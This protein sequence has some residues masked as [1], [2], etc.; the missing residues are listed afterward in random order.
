[1]TAQQQAVIGIDVGTTAVKAAAFGLG[2]ERFGV[3]TRRVSMANAPL[4]RAE[5]NPIALR[6]AVIDALSA[7][8]R[9]VGGTPVRAVSLS[10]AMHGLIGL[11]AKGHPCTPLVTWADG[12]AEAIV[13]DWRTSGRATAL[14]S[15][16]GVPMHPMTPLA[17]LAWFAAEDPSTFAEVHRWADGK[18]LV[19]GWLTGEQSTELSSASGWGLVDLSTQTWDPAALELAGVDVAHMPLIASPTE[20]RPLSP[21][22][23]KRVG[24]RADT[25]VVLGAGDGPLG[26]VGVGAL[27]PG[28]VGLSLGTSGAL[29]MVFDQVP[30]D[31]DDSLFC[32]S[33]TEQ[34]W[35]VGGAVSNGGD[36][37]SWVASALAPD[38]SELAV[39]VPARRVTDGPRRAEE[40]ALDLASSA[41]PGSDG[42]VMIPYLLPERSP[43]WDAGLCGA[44]LGL[45]RRHTRADLARAAI[46]GVCLGM[47]SVLDSLDSVH[48]VHEVRAT[49]GALAAPLWRDV[50]AA[51]LGVP[52]VVANTSEGSAL[53]AAALALVALGEATTLTE[54]VACLA[55]PGVE[56]PQAVPVSPELAEAAAATRAS[57]TGLA[58]S[59]ERTARALGAP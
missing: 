57:I 24:L 46:E 53:G 22:I 9:S 14:P 20:M 15:R 33:L 32:Y 26:N 39:G 36:V 45:R 47:R 54:A 13:R 59:I 4:G 23:A 2:G 30:A 52:M 19:V 43:L 28:I 37:S 7:S 41:P 27:E 10:T 56:V 50:L 21:D 29:R 42:L 11:D 17:K 8:V 31:R 16:T 5:Q 3:V 6:K 58:T 48:P 49:G 25:Q 12:R 40:A 35:A 51:S 38:W 44:Y 55:D 34:T 1:M 18:A